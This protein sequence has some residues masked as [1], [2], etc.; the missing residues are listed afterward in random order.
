MQTL[1]DKA[2]QLRT[3]A[4]GAM[5]EHSEDIMLLSG[6]V[7]SATMLAAA[8]AC[9]YKPRVFTF[10]LSNYVSPDFKVA[11]SMAETFGCAFHPVI[12]PMDTDRLIADVQR[13]I[14]VI[15]TSLKTHV[16]CSHPFLY[17]CEEANRI[18]VSRFIYCSAGSSLYGDGRKAMIMYHQQGE[19]AY[20]KKRLKD[21][22]DTGSSD[23][24]ISALCAIYGVQ[25]HDPYMDPK[26]IDFFGSLKFA[27]MHKP[28]Q[29]YIGLAAFP[30]FWKKGNWYRES[31]NFQINS[32]L[33]EFHDT[34][35]QS[36]L[37]TAGHKSVVGIYNRINN[38]QNGQHL[39]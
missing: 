14:Q 9:G 26:I 28:R 15:K 8:L 30:E 39:T 27:D 36:P 4:M 29:K 18:G 17:L 24:S 31:S 22:E 7:D 1:T 13:V 33:R 16:Q 37:N 20:R 6:G 11:Q 35:L 34:L 19:E 21:A 5:R 23:K 10:R 32:R 12:I 2:N 3:L 25:I 38:E